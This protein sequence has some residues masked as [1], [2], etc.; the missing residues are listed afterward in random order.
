M[1]LIM[2]HLGWIG[3]FGVLHFAVILISVNGQVFFGYRYPVLS[4]VI[5]GT[6]SSTSV[7]LSRKRHPYGGVELSAVMIHFSRSW[8]GR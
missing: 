1:S 6:R 8:S 5:V 7:V 3:S 2:Y 4:G